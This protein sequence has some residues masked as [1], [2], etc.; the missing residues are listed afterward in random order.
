[1]IL[2]SNLLNSP[3][4]K[5][6]LSESIGFKCA[7][8]SNPLFGFDPTLKVGEAL[9]DNPIDPSRSFSLEYKASYSASVISGLSS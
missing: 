9:S 8:F 3:I 2:S 7:C 4:L 5:T 1:M 6:L